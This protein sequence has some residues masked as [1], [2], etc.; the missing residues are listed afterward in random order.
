MNTFFI[1]DDGYKFQQI[2]LTQFDLKQHAPTDIPRHELY[3]FSDS[4]LQMS[5]WWKPLETAFE[6][7]EDYPDGEIPDLSK[8]VGASMILSPRA[9]EALG[10]KLERCGELLPLKIDGSTYY[11][12]NCL[13]EGRIDEINS[14]P[15]KLGEEPSEPFTVA[16]N[17]EDVRDKLV[18]KT[19]YDN[20]SSLYCTEELKQLVENHELTGVSFVSTRETQG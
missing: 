11:L 12:F 16:F 3:L 4:N 5:G 20:C 1:D 8:W 15:H 18:F 9:F 14:K 10:E 7:V 2:L 17:S 6:S 13:T 19:K